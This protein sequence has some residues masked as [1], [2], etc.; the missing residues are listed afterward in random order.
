M[1]LGRTSVRGEV[2]LSIPNAHVIVAPNG[3][4]SYLVPELEE[5]ITPTQGQM[6][7]SVPHGIYS[8]QSLLHSYGFL[9]VG[10]QDRVMSDYL[11]QAPLSTGGHLMY[12]GG[13]AYVPN[14]GSV[15][16]DDSYVDL[17]AEEYLHS[18]PVRLNLGTASGNHES[19]SSSS[20]KL[21]MVVSWTDIMGYSKDHYPWVGRVPNRNIW[22]SCGYTGHGMTN[23]PACGRYIAHLVADDTGGDRMP[24]IE[25]AASSRQEIP[26]EY[27]IS[28]ARIAA[29]KGQT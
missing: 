20:N 9:G 21:D 12:G 14:G 10:Y 24:R 6:S 11:V 3:F 27:I 17:D 29:A 25:N 26:K 23:A 13:S 7:A 4:A 18:L 15:I 2:P 1:V 28:S 19:E 22:G 5:V 8:D 16:S